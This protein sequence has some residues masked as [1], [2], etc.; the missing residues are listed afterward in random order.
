[1]ILNAYRYYDVLN[2]IRVISHTLKL[3]HVKKMG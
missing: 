3:S 1:M 2:Y